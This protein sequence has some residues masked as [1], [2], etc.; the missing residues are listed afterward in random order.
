MITKPRPAHIVMGISALL[1]V[2]SSVWFAVA[3]LGSPRNQDSA[4]LESAGQSRVATSES[5]TTEQSAAT[6]SVP[7]RIS[8]IGEVVPAT[9]VVKGPAPIALE[10]PAIDVV[11][12]V[13]P[14]GVDSD[15][16][17][18]IPGDISQVG[19]YRFGATPGTGIGSS[20]IVGHRDG[21]NYG[22]G[23]F[24]DLGRLGVGDPISV[25]NE[26]GTLITYQV[27]G[28]ETINK[29]K[30][31]FR[32]LFRETGEETLTLISCIGYFEPGVGY[33][34]NIIVS[35]IP[36]SSVNNSPIDSQKS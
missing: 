18:V 4:Q 1:L 36:R 15:Q 8:E 30:L 16:Q 31:P 5:N 34:A 10:I 25:T 19:W 23:A 20:V 11:S 3:G 12:E 2:I 29:S 22:V 27:T 17:V 7:T 35:A 26:A 9:E 33:D 32:E 28:V 14:V 21:R 6:K 13:V 24:Y